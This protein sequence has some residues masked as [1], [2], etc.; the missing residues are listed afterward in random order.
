MTNTD[1]DGR[2]VPILESVVTRLTDRR[3]RGSAAATLLNAC[4]AVGNWRSAEAAWAI[5]LADPGSWLYPGEMRSW[6]GKP[7]TAAAR[8]GAADEAM[9]LWAA[10]V[11]LDRGELSGLE[12]LKKHG[13]GERLRAFYRNLEAR[14]PK[15]KPCTARALALLGN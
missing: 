2:A 13:M 3:A 8:S 9:R 15:A 4:D 5:L 14:D 7:A 12:E 1:A 6:A 11:N 10:K